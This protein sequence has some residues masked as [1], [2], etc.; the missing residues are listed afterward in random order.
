[1]FLS[2]MTGSTLYAI[3]STFLHTFLYDGATVFD[4]DSLLYVHCKKLRT[5]QDGSPGQ[6]YQRRSTST[7]YTSFHQIL[8]NALLK[9]VLGR[10]WP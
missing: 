5:C 6:A 1:M 4:F 10:E 9:S 3:T 8:T 7:Q 2:C